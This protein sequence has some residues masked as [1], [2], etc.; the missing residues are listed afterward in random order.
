MKKMMFLG[1]A[2]SVLAVAAAGSS[3]AVIAY[4]GFDYANNATLN[5]QTGGTNW[6]TAWSGS[7]D[8]KAL[9]TSTLDY[10]DSQ[11]TDLASEGV[12]ARVGRNVRTLAR[13]FTAQSGTD[14]TYWFS[15]LMQPTYTPNTTDGAAANT[16]DLGLEFLIR[17]GTTQRAAIGDFAVS[18]TADPT[19]YG[20]RTSSTA[21][22]AYSAINAET[23]VDNVQ[24][25]H[26]LVLKYIVG[27]TT[28]DG[29]LYLFIDPDIGADN[30]PLESAAD[31]ALTG[32]NSMT[33]STFDGIALNVP[34]GNVPVNRSA[35]NWDEIRVATTYA[36]VT[37][38]AVP[39]PASLSLLA[40]GS[41]APRA[42]APT[43]AHCTPR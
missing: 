29:S 13:T 3:A 18:T 40:L 31:A 21:T 11:S 10:T 7:T 35:G 5:S 23:K 30:E 9:T 39:E 19:N 32:L 26:F 28:T 8:F 12:G 6:A 33:L 2:A 4:E 17:S 22:A 38:A 15:V 20:V 1:A 34:G 16:K 36:E 25:S 24:P 37:G 41:Q 43:P 14:K 27:S 42:D